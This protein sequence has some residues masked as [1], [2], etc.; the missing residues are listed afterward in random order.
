ML[1][2]SSNE[3]MKQFFELVK[4]YSVTRW[5]EQKI[6]QF[7][8]KIA[9]NGA[10]PSYDYITGCFYLIFG[11]WATCTGSQCFLKLPKCFGSDQILLEKKF[12]GPKFHPIWLK[13]FP[14]VLSLNEI[15][16]FF[17]AEK[18][19]YY[20]K[21]QD[22]GPFQKIAQNGAKILGSFFEKKNRPGP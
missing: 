11:L 10:Q 15:S 6:A 7:S 2:I 21:N 19:L 8:E 1:L 18:N 13:K 22:F 9:Q 17:L 12:F 16:S 14:K 20:I 5:F 4:D 3:R